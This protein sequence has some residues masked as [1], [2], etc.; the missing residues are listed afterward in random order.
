V[1]GAGELRYGPNGQTGAALVA[2]M[3]PG[4]A[5]YLDTRADATVDLVVGNAFTTLGAAGT[6]TSAAA[7]N[8]C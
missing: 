1:A 5:F 2:P 8:P 7:A 4:V 6:A 3:I